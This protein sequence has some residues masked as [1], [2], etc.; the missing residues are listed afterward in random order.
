MH[1]VSDDLER[2]K[3]VL[4]TLCLAIT[5]KS[6]KASSLPFFVTTLTISNADLSFLNISLTGKG[7]TLEASLVSAYG[8]LFERLQN[9]FLFTGYSH[10]LP[11]RVGHEAMPERCYRQMQRDGAGLDFYL[12][13]DE[14]F[15]P[16]HA[17]AATSFMDLATILP[18]EI[19]DHD[20]DCGGSEEYFSSL[21]CTPFYSFFD[22]HTGYCPME[23]MLFTSGTTGCAA[24]YN[25]GHA[26]QQA[27]FEI[28]ERYVFHQLFSE[29]L[30][31]PEIPVSQLNGTE[32]GRIVEEI[33]RQHKTVVRLLDCSLG[34]GFP[35]VGV[36]LLDRERH[37]Y[38]CNLGAAATLSDSVIR[39]LTELYDGN[40]DFYG[41]P[42]SGFRNPYHASTPVEEKY[43]RY[44]N[45]Y[46][47]KA[48][49]T[50]LWPKSLFGGDSS[51]QE[52]TAMV[53]NERISSNPLHALLDM[54][55]KAGKKLY[56]RDVSFLGIPSVYGYIPGM[57][58]VNYCSGNHELA[59]VL[60]LREV[61]RQLHKSASRTSSRM[62]HLLALQR[63]IQ[64]TALP[65]PVSSL[66]SFSCWNHPGSRKLREAKLLAGIGQLNGSIAI[67]AETLQQ[68]FLAART[69]DS[70]LAL[71]AHCA[72]DGLQLSVNGCS[73]S[74]IA[75]QLHKFYE[76]P[77]V[78]K[79]ML[80]MENPLLTVLE[81]LENPDFPEDEALCESCAFI[82][83]L[84]Y[85]RKLHSRY[86]D[87]LPDQEHL[88]HAM[89][90]NPII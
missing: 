31:P 68:L 69:T 21:L 22:R 11:G 19:V 6:R 84:S 25:L 83:M 61:S 14:R 18:R 48:N 24:G 90:M 28:C 3:R 81:A 9:N 52:S 79:A 77:V 5:E 12:A 78:E 27:V 49:S 36:M 37:L 55:S 71:V 89:A 2:M 35:V 54:L 88:V 58:N 47:A 38:N 7:T 53:W 40:D 42:L 33:E 39:A 10:A 57:S 34:Q 76:S 85:V 75:R 8:E 72:L 67:A 56:L 63:K 65:A 4:Q 73:P 13:P 46:A 41:L 45:Y 16:L 15:L 74:A 87:C 50:G 23:L 82:S 66:S 60:C 30:S 70:V 62:Q 64:A 1:K 51:W 80:F 86:R 32:A 20:G 44:S 43:L 17:L 29:E 26:V 59:D